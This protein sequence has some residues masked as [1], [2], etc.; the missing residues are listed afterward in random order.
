MNIWFTSDT[1]FNHPNI[2][3]HSARPFA[4]LADM[5]SVIISNW[6]TLVKPGDTVYHL[7]DFALSWGKKHY[8]RIDSILARLNG[9]KWLIAGNHDRDEVRKNPRWVA[10][11]DYHEIKVDLGG[12][13]KQRIVMSHYA[14]RVWNQMHRGAWMLH[15][16][17]HGNLTDVGGKTLDVGVDLHGFAPITLYAISSYMETRSIISYDHHSIQD[18]TNAENT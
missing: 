15:G 1:H 16:H 7:G 2:I 10:V 13:H 17:S 18:D 4:D 11:K 3:E 9:Q 6:N 12:K 14:M 8:D 5:E